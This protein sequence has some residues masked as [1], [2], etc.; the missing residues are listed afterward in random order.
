MDEFTGVWFI[1]DE[2]ATN[3]KSK[4]YIFMIF[5]KNPSPHKAPPNKQYKLFVYWACCVSL[6][7]AYFSTISAILS[8]I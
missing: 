2:L 7:Y 5:F 6:C 4:Q 3:D 8:G 1:V